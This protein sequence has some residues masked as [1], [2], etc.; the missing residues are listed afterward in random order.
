MVRLFVWVWLSVWYQASREGCC[1]G[2]RFKPGISVMVAKAVALAG[3]FAAATWPCGGIV[4][5]N[6]Y[7]CHCVLLHLQLLGL[8]GCGRKRLLLLWAALDLVRTGGAGPAAVAAGSGVVPGELG[9]AA[10]A[11]VD[12]WALLRLS[13]AAMEPP[14]QPGQQVKLDLSLFDTLSMRYRRAHALP[15]PTG[16][17]LCYCHCTASFAPSAEPLYLVQF[18]IV[19]MDSLR[20]TR[21]MTVTRTV[22]LTRAKCLHSRL[23]I[24]SSNGPE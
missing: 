24:R 7:N 10:G 13:L 2:C 11:A 9:P 6:I 4:G 1:C 18:G 21:S 17:S 12:G 3:C 19:H 8:A 23:D 20:H 16:D 22:D 5:T 15:T 14:D